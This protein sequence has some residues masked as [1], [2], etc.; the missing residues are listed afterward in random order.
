MGFDFGRMSLMAEFIFVFSRVA[1][2]PL[3]RGVGWSKPTTSV[4]RSHR[5]RE[6]V[7]ESLERFQIHFV[8]VKLVSLHQIPLW[9][10]RP[11][12]AEAFLPGGRW[13]RPGNAPQPSERFIWTHCERRNSRIWHGERKINRKTIGIFLRAHSGTRHILEILIPAIYLS[14]RPA[15]HRAA[16]MQNSSDT[17]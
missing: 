5:G 14:K 7:P 8:K 11:S 3:Y 13:D 6:N 15:G 1:I 4:T 16:L 17:P 10:G 9:N 12:P 2:Q